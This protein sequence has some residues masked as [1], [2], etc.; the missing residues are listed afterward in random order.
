MD[1]DADQIRITVA[2]GQNMTADPTTG[3][4]T[5]HD[6]VAFPGTDANAGTTRGSSPP[7]TPTPPIST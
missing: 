3:A 7:P 4:A 5:V 1:P 6:D 2:T